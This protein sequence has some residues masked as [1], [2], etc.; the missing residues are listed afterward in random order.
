MRQPGK[1][2]Y[3]NIQPNAFPI[4]NGFEGVA[5]PFNLNVAP[6]RVIIK[7]KKIR[8]PRISK[9]LIRNIPTILPSPI[10]KVKVKVKIVPIFV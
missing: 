9:T 2:V 7:R 10:I 1:T 3:A 4:H 8:N 6:E 5:A